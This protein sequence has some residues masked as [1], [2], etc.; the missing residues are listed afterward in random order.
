ML[1][2]VLT[3]LLAL[4]AFAPPIAGYSSGSPERAC[5]HMTPGHNGNK[6][7]SPATA[8]YTMYV[9]STRIAPGSSVR[10]KLQLKNRGTYF[11]G[12][13]IQVSLLCNGWRS[14]SMLI[15]VQLHVFCILC[16]I[17]HA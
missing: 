1:S 11:K 13:M 14:P 12:F 5:D 10:I 2:F 17:E 9:S 4:T 15:R 7:Q 6:A 8:P 3:T 16:T